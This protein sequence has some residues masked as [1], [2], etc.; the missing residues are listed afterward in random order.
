MELF[1]LPAMKARLAELDAERGPL[2]AMIAA[3]ERYEGIV[4]KTIFSTPNV[5]MRQ[6]G[7]GRAAPMMA[8]T[9]INV[10]RLLAIAE[11]PMGTA[12]L[13]EALESN[14]LLGLKVT[15]ASNILSA[16]LSNSKKFVGRRGQGWWFADRPWPGEEEENEA[17]AG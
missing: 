6:R 1:D 2:T 11:R 10:A 8:A 17:P 9:E 5:T 3:A 16:R 12:E 4:G 15:N 14:E 13:I 7:V